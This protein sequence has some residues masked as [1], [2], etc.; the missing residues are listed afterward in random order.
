MGVGVPGAA[1][2]SLYPEKLIAVGWK[3]D[4][5]C[6]LLNTVGGQDGFAEG[7]DFRML[8]IRTSRD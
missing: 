3:R 7:A 8:R 1:R 5:W 2:H 6:L 4:T